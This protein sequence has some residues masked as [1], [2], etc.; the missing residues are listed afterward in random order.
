MVGQLALSREGRSDEGR[1]LGLE[2]TIVGG[3][4]ALILQDVVFAREVGEHIIVGIH[5]GGGGGDWC[6]GGAL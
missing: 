5:V 4:V 2:R 6:R 3:V 1:G